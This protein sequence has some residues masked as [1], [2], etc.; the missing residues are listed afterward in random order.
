M[1][2][3]VRLPSERGMSTSD[4]LETDSL[5][6][7]FRDRVQGINDRI[8]MENQRADEME[9]QQQQQQ[10]HYDNMLQRQEEL[11]N[12]V[13]RIRDKIVE[14]TTEDLT[15]RIK[16]QGEMNTQLEQM[17]RTSQEHRDEV[18]RRLDEVV[19]RRRECGWRM[20]S[21]TTDL[22]HTHIANQR[23]TNEYNEVNESLT[24]K[25]VKVV[26]MEESCVSIEARCA[27]AI[28][29]IT[30][31][32]TRIETAEKEL[33][34]FQGESQVM[35]ANFREML[36]AAHSDLSVMYATTT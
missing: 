11:K 2:Q 25:E 22:E 4:N 6:S 5:L 9:Q 34:R 17:I 14:V 24:W 30:G 8:K 36:L 23:K 26:D 33:E 27:S 32:E 20:D 19:E 15:L 18:E 10:Q 35:Q 16:T 7:G 21:L 1:S 28:E 12:D 13:Q 29:K 31:L 3:I